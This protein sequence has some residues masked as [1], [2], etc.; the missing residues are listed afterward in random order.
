MLPNLFEKSLNLNHYFKYNRTAK[1]F[2]HSKD[3]VNYSETKYS[4][5]NKNKILSWEGQF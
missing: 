1:Y 2:N 4:Q 3:K 5:Q